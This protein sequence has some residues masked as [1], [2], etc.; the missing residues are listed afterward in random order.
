METLG[1]IPSIRTLQISHSKNEIFSNRRFTLTK[2]FWFS[3]LVMCHSF[4]IFHSFLYDNSFGEVLVKSFMMNSHSY[5]IQNFF[6]SITESKLILVNWP[7]VFSLFL[8]SWFEI[9]MSFFIH[10]L[11][12]IILH[13][14][15]HLSLISFWI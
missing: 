1:C 6:F 14:V 5:A 7:L 15:I 4:H 3:K 12:L 11:G 9:S 8:F 13:P 10:Y 2:I